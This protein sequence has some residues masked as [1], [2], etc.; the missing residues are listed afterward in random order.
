[1]IE[2][3]G[4]IL[5]T[6]RIAWFFVCG[7]IDIARLAF[8]RYAHIRLRRKQMLSVSPPYFALFLCVPGHKERGVLTA[9][10]KLR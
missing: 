2:C 6:A 3:S 9:A 5:R 1:M 8:W 10:R 7:T 4:T